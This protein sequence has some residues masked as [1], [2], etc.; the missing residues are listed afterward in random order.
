[1][2]FFIFNFFNLDF[3]AAASEGAFL[4]LFTYEELKS[5]KSDKVTLKCLSEDAGLLLTDL[6]LLL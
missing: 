6:I 2:T 4:S 5:K 3:L 1:M